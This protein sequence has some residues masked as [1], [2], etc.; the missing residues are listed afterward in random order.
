MAAAFFFE[1]PVEAL[2][3]GPVPI[4]APRAYGGSNVILLAKGTIRLRGVLMDWSE[5][6]S[7]DF[8]FR[9]RLLDGFRN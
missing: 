2:H 3:E 1:M 4:I 5:Q 7:S 8:F 9:F 6:A